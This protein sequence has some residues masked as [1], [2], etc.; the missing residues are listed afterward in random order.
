MKS[1]LPSP[2]SQGSATSLGVSF[3]GREGQGILSTV[4]GGLAGWAP[5]RLENCRL[6]GPGICETGTRCRR[7]CLHGAEREEGGEVGLPGWP[8]WGQTTARR[9]MCPCPLRRSLWACL[10]SF[11]ANKPQ[12]LGNVW[13]NLG[14]WIQTFPTL[15]GPPLWGGAQIM[16]PEGEWMGSS[17]IPHPLSSH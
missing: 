10:R 16:D 1:P 5:L 17:S 4:P 11:M 3:C 2:Q 7:I 9:V 8:R 15:P 6:R 12:V 13:P 14:P